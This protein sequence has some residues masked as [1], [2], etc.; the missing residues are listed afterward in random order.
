M[1]NLINIGRAEV[2]QTLSKTPG[3]PYTEL[4]QADEE[5]FRP[6][7]NKWRPANEPPVIL[8][9]WFMT[10]WCNYKCPYC[11]QTHDRDAPKGRGLTAH[12]FDNFPIERWLAS[13][14]RH[15]ADKRLSLV[16]TGGEPFV[17]R[18]SMLPLL[19]FLTS[20]PG[21]ECIRI[22]T[23]AWW[24]PD[25]YVGLDKSR[26]TLMCTFHP[27]QVS[28]ERF[29][30]KVDALLEAGFQIGMVNYVMTAD[31]LEHYVEFREAL[32]RKNVPLH[33]NPLWDAAGK[34][35][36]EALELLRSEL[37]VTDFLYRTGIRAPRGKHCLF[38]GLAYE[39]DYIG[40]IHVGCH[41]DASGSFF[42]QT[43][44]DLF[45]GPAPCPHTSCVCLDKYSFR[46]ES[47]RN[48][49]WDPLRIYGEVLRG[50]R[51]IHP[52]S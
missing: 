39:M 1:T 51:G 36:E 32:G 40:E 45:A 34:Y 10:E 23:N 30:A 12:A 9:R 24:H 6:V 5:L 48:T 22:D 41:R 15:F 13:F 49:G 2:T 27:S 20:R 18:H 38:P 42:D 11:S 25:T 29:F 50:V 33:P 16:I 7:L 31:N 3:T 4:S 52:S 26:I 35:S 43:L 19:Q 8:L 47:N 37:P 28:A 14:E 46:A 21:A 44:P 17:D